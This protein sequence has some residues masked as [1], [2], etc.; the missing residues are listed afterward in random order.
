MAKTNCWEFKK[1]GREKGGVKTGEL[2]ICPA[3][4]EPRLNGLHG[5]RNGGR[6]CWVMGGTLCGGKVQGSFAAKLGNC[7]KCEFY[8]A[9]KKEEGS[10]F[11]GTKEIL[12]K[13]K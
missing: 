1:C 9:V 10:Q 13:L 2:G 6:S 4:I 12:T 3:S 5:G 11:T 7:L 8:Q